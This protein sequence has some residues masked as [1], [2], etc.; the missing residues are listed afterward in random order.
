MLL[1]RYGAVENRTAAQARLI[2]KDVFKC[3]YEPGSLGERLL[4]YL[5]KS[6]GFH[7][8]PW[9]KLSSRQA[10]FNLS[11]SQTIS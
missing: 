1:S 4:G 7:V 10:Q 5:K 6:G 3:N 11:L 2:L 9:L 8:K